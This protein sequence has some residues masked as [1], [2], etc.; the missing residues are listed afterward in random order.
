MFAIA[1]AVETNNL[2]GLEYYTNS[3]LEHW[4]KDHANNGLIEKLR[5]AFGKIDDE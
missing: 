5:Q 3:Q 1:G 2:I 4:R